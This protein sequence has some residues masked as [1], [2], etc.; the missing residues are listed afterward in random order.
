ML[1]VSPITEAATPAVN[2][3]FKVRLET[4]DTSMPVAFLRFINKSDA[5]LLYF[6]GQKVYAPGNA[7]NAMTLTA[8][9]WVT[10]NLFIDSVGNTMTA[11]LTNEAGEEIEV[12]TAIVERNFTRIELYTAASSADYTSGLCIDDLVI[13]KAVGETTSLTGEVTVT[14]GAE[15]TSVTVTLLK[16]GVEVATAEATAETNWKYTFEDLE[17]YDANGTAHVYTVE[18]AENYEEEEANFF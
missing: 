7:E 5:A 4:A 10:V 11:K 13:T 17:L 18:T 15:P 12:T 9:K 1:L 2:M 6:E 16:D 14:E 8:D 3:S